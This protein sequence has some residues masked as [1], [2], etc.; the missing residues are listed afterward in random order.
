MLLKHFSKKE[1]KRRHTSMLIDL[2][3]KKKPMENNIF[4][5]TVDTESQPTYRIYLLLTDSE[6][7][8][9]RNAV[10]MVKD[11]LNPELVNPLT[12]ERLVQVV[13]QEVSAYLAPVRETERIRKI[14][15]LAS[16]ECI[17]LSRIFALCSD[18]MVSEF[19]CDSETT[20]VYLDHIRYGRCDT[21][22]VLTERERD[23][24]ETHLDTFGGYSLDFSTPSLKH[25]IEVSGKKLRVSLDLEPLAV[26][27]FALDVRRI[28]PSGL[29]MRQLVSMGTITAEAASFIVSWVELGGNVTIIGETGTGKTTLMNAIDREV[30]PK[31]RR[32]YIEDAVETP[33]LLGKG[34]HQLKLRVEPYD[35]RNASRTKGFES[36]KML[37][38][39]PDLMILSE[40]QSEEH[41][42]ALFSSLEAGIR[43]LQTFHSSSPEQAIRR[44]TLIH[45]ISEQSLVDLG[46]LVQMHRPDRLKPK[47]V[48]SR[49]SQIVLKEGKVE[50]VNV[51]VIGK[52]GK[53]ESTHEDR[54]APPPNKT[55]IEFLS[56]IAR[57][58]NSY[59]EL[60]I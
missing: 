24:L 57:R 59:K 17:G 4:L 34:Y 38:R 53:L 20:P 7:E 32:V 35:K 36:V 29:T 40:I 13:R 47:R 5:A 42:K 9:I 6:I 52:Q 51:F 8:L 15:E 39:S 43:G 31:L 27:R 10:T 56:E 18:D 2:F 48:V 12:F 37:H 25:D 44:W 21:D 16:Y 45:G 41:S 26:N 28:E 55:K 22:I 11:T 49:I 46:L 19:F 50:I 54:I 1:K 14:S 33:D 23:A 58:T 3:E 30:N 60:L